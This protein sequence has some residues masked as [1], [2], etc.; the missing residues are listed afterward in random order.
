MARQHLGG[1][2]A[3]AYLNQRYKGGA[4]LAV[5]TPEQRAMVTAYSEQKATIKR[6]TSEADIM[7]QRIALELGDSNGWEG[8]CTFRPN[9]KGVRSLLLTAEKE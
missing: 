4:P 5:A 2:A 9:K 1:N 7:R 6:L 3:A 8:L